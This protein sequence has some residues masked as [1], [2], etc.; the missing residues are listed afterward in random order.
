MG[1]EDDAARPTGVSDPTEIPT[2]PREDILEID[3]WQTDHIRRAL[4]QAD[5]GE[6]AAADEI[7]AAFER[8][9]S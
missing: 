3:R 4:N 8:W 1:M 9:R 2:R 6:F 5:A 7:A